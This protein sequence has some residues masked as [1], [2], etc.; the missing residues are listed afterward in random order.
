MPN[1]LF[2]ISSPTLRSTITDYQVEFPRYQRNKA[3]GN[4][5]KFKLFIS[6]FKSYPIGSI[7]VKELVE[8]E[9]LWILDGRQRYE[10]I[11]DMQNPETVFEWAKS[12]CGFN[13]KDDIKSVLRDKISDYLGYDIDESSDLW[14]TDLSEVI[15]TVGRIRKKKGKSATSSGF[16]DPFIYKKF[17]PNY[18]VNLGDCF[19]ADPEK[20]L[21]WILGSGLIKTADLEKLTDVDILSKN[22][23]RDEEKDAVLEEIKKNLYEMKKSLKAVKIVQTAMQRNQLSL[24]TL[25]KACRSSDEMKIFEIVNTGGKRLNNAQIRSAKKQWNYVV[26]DIIDGDPIDKFRNNLYTAQDLTLTVRVSWDFAATFVDRLNE[27]SDIILSKNYRTMNYSVEKCKDKMEFGFKLLSARFNKSVTK[28]SIDELPEKIG[29]WSR[30]CTAYA[31]DIN[32]LSDYLVSHDPVLEK[33]SDY[34][35]SLF[36]VGQNVSICFLILALERWEFYERATSGQK[37]RSFLK[38]VRSLLDSF[39][40]DYISDTWKG[41][42]DSL[43]RIKLE[44]GFHPEPVDNEKWDALVDELYSDNELSIGKLTNDKL[45]VLTFYFTAL[46]NIS[47]HGNGERAHIDH[48]IPKSQFLEGTPEEFMR[49]RDSLINY[50]LLPPKLNKEKSDWANS[51]T[52]PEKEDICSFESLDLENLELISSAA[53]VPELKRMR[54]SIPEDIKSK[55]K[56]YVTCNNYWLIR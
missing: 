50:A 12:F 25:D 4:E 55:H 17:R 9:R 14:F 32:D 18:I 33:L 42:G 35:F 19:D 27:N 54:S 53:G 30:D 10:T 7:V 44:N 5:D 20:L 39:I 29:D 40:Y 22:D 51:L 36:D 23:V 47:I 52:M 2:S 26:E 31:A 6:V 21:S 8:G 46:R 37:S 34:G 48:I 1:D 13:E 56:D 38:D 49:F 15:C 11:R 24:I 3:W 41:S 43:L 28:E 16:R 45:G